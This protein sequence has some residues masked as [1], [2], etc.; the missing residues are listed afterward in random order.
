MMG[1]FE[2]RFFGRC[3]ECP[4]PVRVGQI[5]RFN[6]HGAVVHAEHPEDVR[7]T[8]PEDICPFCHMVMPVNGECCD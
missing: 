6:E 7:E 3:D 4:D 8:R 2:A 1:T 5:A